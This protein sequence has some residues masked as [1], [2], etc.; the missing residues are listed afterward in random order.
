MFEEKNFKRQKKIERER[1]I[2][3]N[4]KKFLRERKAV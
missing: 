3:L 2:S 4:V 1:K